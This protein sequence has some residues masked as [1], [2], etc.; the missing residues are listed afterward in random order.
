[1]CLG[2]DI[3]LA[4]GVMKACMHG[5]DACFELS[6]EAD[7]A[8]IPVA[9]DA[10]V[11]AGAARPRVHVE[12]HRAHPFASGGDRGGRSGRATADDQDIGG[13]MNRDG[14]WWDR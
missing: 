14:G 9:V 5:V 13:A 4:A 3:P 8:A 12:E 7:V 11:G 10:A 6:R 2:V 1:M